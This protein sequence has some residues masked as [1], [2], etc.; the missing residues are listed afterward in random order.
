[1]TNSVQ[2]K[3][4][5]TTPTQDPTTPATDTKDFV[6]DKGTS[7]K[8][9]T[10]P[11]GLFYIKMEAGGKRPPLCDGLFTSKKL[12]VVALEQY[13]QENDRAGYAQFPSKKAVNGK[14]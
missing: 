13:L 14:S 6:S 10:V 11:S 5:T 12:A 8:I 9:A 1:M 7:F 3:L 4:S 2:E